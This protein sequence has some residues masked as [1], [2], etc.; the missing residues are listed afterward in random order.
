MDELN[1][2]DAGERLEGALRANGWMEEFPMRFLTS[3]GAVLEAE[4]ALEI[5]KGLQA[6]DGFAPADIEAYILE[7]VARIAPLVSLGPVADAAR[8]LEERAD[9]IVRALV[10]VGLLKPAPAAEEGPRASAAASPK[11]PKG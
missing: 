5:L 9:A 3:D 7:L 6:G 4:T 10:E 1:E 2:P 8:P 11:A